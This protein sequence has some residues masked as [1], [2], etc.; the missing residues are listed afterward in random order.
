MPELEEDGDEPDDPEAELP[1]S[2]AK[3]GIESAS[4]RAEAATAAEILAIRISPLV[5]AQRDSKTRTGGKV[6]R[7]RLMRA[8]P[9][10][11]GKA[12][13]ESQVLGPAPA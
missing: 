6:P 9:N 4:T 7:V 10:R 11:P 8:R 2:A 12:G 13:L 3:A 5:I 1:V